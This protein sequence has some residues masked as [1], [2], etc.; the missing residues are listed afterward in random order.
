M[1]FGEIPVLLHP[2]SQSATPPSAGG[3]RDQ[4][5][6]GVVPLVERIGPDV[7]EAQEPLDAVRFDPNHAGEGN[8]SGNGQQTRMPEAGTRRQD[9]QAPD[10]HDQR[11]GPQVFNHDESG[12][13][14][15]DQHGGDDPVPE[16]LHQHATMGQPRGQKNDDA[17]LGEFG[18]LKTESVLAWPELQPAPRATTRVREAGHKSSD[19]AN[20]HENEEQEGRFS[21]PAFALVGHVVEQV[22]AQRRASPAQTSIADA[23]GDPHQGD[24]QQ[25][26]CDLP[27]GDGMEWVLREQGPV[28]SAA[29]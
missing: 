9:H 13:G 22:S 4:R 23:V 5:L 6:H 10:Q 17:D 12:N 21:V 28:K 8:E 26:E 24:R 18:R 2:G 15:Q 14:T 27:R 3:D 1:G 29:G 11:G 25:R 19:Q 7:A 16:L 20:Q